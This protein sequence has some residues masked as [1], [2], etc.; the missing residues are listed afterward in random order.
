MSNLT[1]ACKPVTTPKGKRT[2]AE[3]GYPEIQAQAKQPLRDAAAVN[4]T[5]WA[6]YHRLA[7]LGLPL[8]TGT[9][10]RTKWNRTSEAA[11]DAL[12]RRRVCGGQH[13][14]Y[15]W[16]AGDRPAT[17]HGNGTAQPADVSHERLRLPRQSAQG[18][19]CGRRIPDRR[20][21]ARR[22][23]SP[24]KAGTYVGRLAMRATGSC[25]LT[26]ATGTVQGI[27]VRYCLRSIEVTAIP[28]RKER[29]YLPRPEGWGPCAPTSMTEIPRP[30]TLIV[31]DGYGINPRPDANAIAHA[32]K[33]NLDRIARTGRRHN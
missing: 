24:T 30:L 32:R 10:G 21:R 31:M 7:A 23:P 25:N 20:H 5:R 8:E 19:Q 13:A 4:A 16:S 29:R 9:G 2:A 6:L 18:D 11:Q 22:V 28:I 15:A 1:I 17:H 26:T 14:C 27:H 33:P 3:F 12:A